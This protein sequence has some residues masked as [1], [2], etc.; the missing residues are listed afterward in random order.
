MASLQG[1]ASLR[2]GVS[3]TGWGLSVVFCSST[4][5]L[6]GIEKRD[7]MDSH[8]KSPLRHSFVFI[9]QIFSLFPFC[10]VLSKM[11]AA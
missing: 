3:G 6:P 5:L 7:D 1:P 9:P 10:R 2:A 4:D 8:Q 11:K